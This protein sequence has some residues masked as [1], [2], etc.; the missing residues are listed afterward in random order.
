MRKGLKPIGEIIGSGPR[1]AGLSRT[2][3]LASIAVA[4][5]EHMRAKFSA[6][7]AVNSITEGVIHVSVDE[8]V[9]AQQMSMLSDEIISELGRHCDISGIKGIKFS[10]FGSVQRPKGGKKAGFT[11]SDIYPV[12]KELDSVRL[13][14]DLDG[15]LRK[16]APA[17]PDGLKR[18]YL[19]SLK[20]EALSRAKKS[21]QCP[22]CSAPLPPKKR[23]CDICAT[24][25][26][27]GRIASAVSHL[28]EIPLSTDEDLIELMGI[29][30][31]DPLVVHEL[32][33][34]SREA[35][36][37]RLY[38]EAVI[39]A[40]DADEAAGGENKKAWSLLV[41]G[42]CASTGKAYDAIITEGLEKHVPV[43][44][45]MAAGID[46]NNPKSRRSVPFRSKKGEEA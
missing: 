32:V 27:K 25:P 3:S 14:P 21:P 42:A 12:A 34:R 39:S 33:D 9:W 40:G 46:E 43:A 18:S 30:G 20:S 1:R 19:L 16:L 36:G 41:A 45:L 24:L 28:L 35:A 2:L 10:S 37:R 23:Y 6:G 5:E 22:I 4:W 26:D 7:S 15:R 8:P 38:E 17:L 13:S 29:E 11:R 44:I 31:E